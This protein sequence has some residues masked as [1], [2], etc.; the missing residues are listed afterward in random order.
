[1]KRPQIFQKHDRESAG[2]ADPS[3]LLLV[4]AQDGDHRAFEAFVRETHDD[5]QRFCS[6]LC[7]PGADLDDLVQETFLRAF[8]G[9]HT[10]GNVASARSWLMTIARRV[11]ADH[12]ARLIRDRRNLAVTPVSLEH[13]DSIAG[14]VELT[15]N[16]RD[17]TPTYRE[18]F[19]LVAV[20]GF[21]YEEAG[22]ILDCPRGTVQSRVA[23]ARV[24]LVSML[25]EDVVTDAC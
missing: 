24:Q 2:A 25:N 23:R 6:W 17:V 5:V 14:Y 1:M 7:H 10:Y 22:C 13:V 16:F 20:M 3:S 12:V 11:C 4:L 15:A 18:A 8:K 21:T 9:L 19:L